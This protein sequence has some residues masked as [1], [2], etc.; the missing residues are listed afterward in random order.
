MSCS[1]SYTILIS[2]FHRHGGGHCVYVQTLAKC[3]LKLGHRLL[4]ACP[5]ESQL[6]KDCGRDG[7]E[8]LDCFYFDGG[9]TPISFYR[10]VAVANRI[11]GENCIDLIHVNGSRDHWVMATA[12][13]LSAKKLPLVRTRH[14]TNPVK[15]TALSRVL[16]QKL[17]NRTISVCQHVKEMLSE[18]PVFENHGI[19]V[20]HNGIELEK[21]APRAPDEA[22]REEFGIAPEEIVIGIVGRLEWDKGHKYLFEAVAPLIK[23]EF[24]NI[25]VLVVGFG[26]G[27]EKLLDMCRE[28]DIAHRV[29]FAGRRADMREVISLFDIGAHPSIGVDTSSFAMKEMMAMEKPIVS[30][31][32]GGLKE[33]AE[34]GV[35]GFVVPTHDS[36]AL[37]QRIVDLYHSGELRAKMG[38]AARKKVEREFTAEISARKTLAVY[39]SAIEGP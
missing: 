29:V 12:N 31:S 21:F 20:I 16:N 5:S 1:K 13:L 26:E 19:D 35:T 22:V 17:T 36:A 8:V 39:E 11:K 24:G 37:R 38:A 30:S 6:A 27:Y 34:E 23:G 3:L 14:N 28:L 10:D 9:F 18:S 4:V 15:N 7:I 2:D 33:I 32:Y 25:K